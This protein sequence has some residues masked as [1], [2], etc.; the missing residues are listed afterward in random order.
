MSGYDEVLYVIGAMLIFSMLTLQAN[1]MFISNERT[2]VEG[3]VEYNAISVAQDHIDRIKWMS[4]EFEVNSFA[5]NYPST[6][7]VE[8]GQGN[9]LPYYVE[10]DIT[11]ENIDDS[12]VVNKHVTVTVKSKYL[13]NEQDPAENTTNYAKMEFIKSFPN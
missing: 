6:I 7:N 2:T 8:S 5:S 1:R 10:I 13:G 11:S 12:N 9:T 3:Q 4:S